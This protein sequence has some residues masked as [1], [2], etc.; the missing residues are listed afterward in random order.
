MKCNSI[1]HGEIDK[2]ALLSEST[3][4]VLMQE[5]DDTSYCHYCILYNGFGCV[6]AKITYS[7][8]SWRTAPPMDLPQNIPTY[9]SDDLN[10]SGI[11]NLKQG[12]MSPRLID[13]GLATQ[14]CK[15]VISL[16]G[17]IHLYRTVLHKTNEHSLPAYEYNAAADKVPCILSLLTIILL[18]ESDHKE[19]SMELQQL[20]TQSAHMA[21][22]NFAVL[23][24]TTSIVHKQFCRHMNFIMGNF[25]MDYKYYTQDLTF[26]WF[27]NSVFSS[28]TFTQSLLREGIKPRSLVSSVL[29]YVMA[30]SNNLLMC[31]LLPVCKGS[32]NLMIGT[33]LD[34]YSSIYAVMLTSLLL[35]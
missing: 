21:I 13:A 20:Q 19:F 30:Y 7:I 22:K 25:V 6:S 27:C 28:L 12:C 24:W 4:F 26:R 31:C 18:F 32:V 23:N 10:D 5:L 14:Q 11:P 2:G 33:S 8:S 9:N 15:S 35:N 1:F 29:A 17:K 34:H 3:L 16:V